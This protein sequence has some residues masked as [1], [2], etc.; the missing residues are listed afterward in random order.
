MKKNDNNNLSTTDINASDTTDVN[1]AES[2]DSEMSLEEAF[3]AID[4]RLNALSEDIPL[5]RAFEL[6]KEGMNLLKL[7]DEKIDKVEKQVLVLNE[8]GGLDEF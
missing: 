7:C 3:F 2:S 5:E 1:M 6:Y 8:E 4:E